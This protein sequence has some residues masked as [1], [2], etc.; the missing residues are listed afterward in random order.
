M[1]PAIALGPHVCAQGVLPGAPSSDWQSPAGLWPLPQESWGLSGLGTPKCSEASTRR[2]QF[3]ALPLG[4]LLGCAG[5]N[6]PG[7]VPVSSLLDPWRGDSGLLPEGSR[8]PQNRVAQVGA[9]VPF[10]RMCPRLRKPDQARSLGS[11]RVHC[12]GPVESQSVCGGGLPEEGQ[13]V[14]PKGGWLGKGRRPERGGG[15]PGIQSKLGGA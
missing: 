13:E 14:G 9:G 1:C 15:G 10:S 11:L 5:P 4:H 7:P 2:W 12:T 8:E 3:L 6:C